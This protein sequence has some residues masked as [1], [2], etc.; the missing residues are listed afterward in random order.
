MQNLV[1]SLSHTVCAHVG[2]PK[3]WDG[4]RRERPSQVRK[5]WGTG[6]HVP[7]EFGVG[8]E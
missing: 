7:T 4:R 8:G 1:V 6:G 2:G 5:P 3:I